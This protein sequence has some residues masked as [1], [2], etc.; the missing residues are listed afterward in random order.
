MTN[1]SA[2]GVLDG[3]WAFNESYPLGS[4]A[5]NQDDQS[6]SIRDSLGVP[7]SWGRPFNEAVRFGESQDTCGHP[8]N[9]QVRLVRRAPYGQGFQMAKGIGTVVLLADGVPM[10]FMGQ[11]GGEDNDFFFDYHPA[12][13]RDDVT[14][15][16]RLD[17]Y[18]TPGDDH[19]RILAWFRDLIGLRNNPANGLGG[20]DYQITGRGNKTVAFTRSHNRF[21]VVASLGTPDNRQTLSWLGL[22]ADAGYKEI[23]NSSWPAYQVVSET[24]YTNG[25]YDAVLTADS[26]I[27]VPPIGGIVLERR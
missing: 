17:L 24:D 4:A 15:F 20:D 3:Q 27:N 5:H 18:Q 23:F 10:L 16:A 1:V 7:I 11:E 21:F 8:E 6:W 14:F 26:I 25:G 2:G 13:N 9:G 22:P 19:N 12:V